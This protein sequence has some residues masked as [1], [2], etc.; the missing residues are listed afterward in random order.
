MGRPLKEIDGEEVFRLAK[1]GCTQAEIAGHFGCAQST[2]SAR[3]RLD[4]ELGS[5]QSKTSLRRK[6]FERAMKGSDVMLIHL[7]KVY[8]GQTD[9]IDITSEGKSL[10]YVDRA[11][12]PR[13]TK[14]LEH[15]TNGSGNGNGNG[16]APLPSP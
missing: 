6:Q 2:I 1:R 14:A 11:N 13:D 15:S 4:F 10:K 5:A 12:N 16:V 7:G 9:R 8:L 3:F